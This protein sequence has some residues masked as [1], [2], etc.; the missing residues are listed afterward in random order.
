MSRAIDQT[1]ERIAKS[2]LRGE[3]CAIYAELDKKKDD[4]GGPGQS[5][6][7]KAGDSSDRIPRV[8]PMNSEVIAVGSSRDSD[9]PKSKSRHFHPGH[10][11]PRQYTLLKFYELNSGA[12]KLLLDSKDDQGMDLPFTPG[13]KEHEIIHYKTDPQRSVLLMGRR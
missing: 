4:E 10:D 6:D 8:F 3:D 5:L 2:H 12:V 13:P 1:L 7:G 9:T 11:D